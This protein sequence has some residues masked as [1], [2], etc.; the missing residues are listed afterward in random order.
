[1]TLHEVMIIALMV[2]GYILTNVCVI[3]GAWYFN[4]ENSINLLRKLMILMLLAAVVF[5]GNIVNVAGM[6]F[7]I[8]LGIHI[9]YFLL[10]F[11]MVQIYG[12]DKYIEQLR[13]HFYTLL[14]FAIMILPL[15]PLQTA[16]VIHNS[17]S[18]PNNL[19]DDILVDRFSLVALLVGIYYIGQLMY[20]HSYDFLP[21]QSFYFEFLIRLPVVM[22][23]QSTI[24]YF[25][26]TMITLYQ[27]PIEMAHQIIGENATLL[28]DGFIVRY[29]L[30]LI[31]SVP[32]YYVYMEK[33][34]DIQIDE[35]V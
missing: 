1:M 12:H 3:A 32:F 26:Q 2:S 25:L 21:R 33:Q 5:S 23:I 7:N 6:P 31:A 22:S 27:R 29:L 35:N 30:V 19:I 13:M 18:F 14:V 15:A 28:A 17:A 9:N 8:G 20:A 16:G 10:G 24:F 11:V 34:K 4:L